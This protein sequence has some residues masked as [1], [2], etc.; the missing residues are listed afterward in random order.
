MVIITVLDAA[1]LVH[2]NRCK[3]QMT[4][5]EHSLTT[6]QRSGLDD[7]QGN[8]EDVVAVG[9]IRGTHG[10]CRHHAQVVI[11]RVD[12][13][14]QIIRVTILAVG[15]LAQHRDQIAHRGR[16]EIA[17]LDLCLFRVG[18]AADHGNVIAHIA[19][20]ANGLIVAVAHDN[21]LF[22]TVRQ[23]FRQNCAD[24]T[25]QPLGTKIQLRLA[26]RN[27][28][29]KLVQT[30]V[31]FLEAGGQLFH[32]LGAQLAPLGL[33]DAVGVQHHAD[34]AAGGG[35]LDLTQ[36]G[37]LGCQI[38]HHAADN[39]LREHN[40]HVLQR[41]LG[42]VGAHGLLHGLI[43]LA[44]V[45]GQLTHA[46]GV[47]DGVVQLLLHAVQLLLVLL[48]VDVAHGLE[49]LQEG[50]SHSILV[51]AL[52][53]IVQLL[54]QIVQLLIVLV[55]FRKIHVDFSFLVFKKQHPHKG[56]AALRLIFRYCKAS[57]SS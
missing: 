20:H 16:F 51:V 46:A 19:H 23:S 18:L 42:V 21:A 35:K 32:D 28:R 57:A 25:I 54:A 55:Q 43:V 13:Q 7:G 44:L 47:Q 27:K 2:A 6:R 8:R 48:A 15:S 24:I 36:Q 29:R 33:V 56:S 45:V 9:A 30:C 12:Q 10:G 17:D 50:V 39:R 14:D 5:T 34:R 11:L 52:V 38:V 53:S 41:L 1:V 4:D 26:D 22:Q 31:H 3:V 37:V 49:H 40:G